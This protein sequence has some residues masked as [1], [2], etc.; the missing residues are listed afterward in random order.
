M[1]EDMMTNIQMI[2]TVAM[3][4]G[5]LNNEVVFLGGA[6]TELLITDPAAPQTRVSLDVDVIIEIPSRRDFYKLEDDLRSRG[7]TQSDNEDD[8]PICRWRIQNIIVDVMP[9]DSRILGFSNMWYSPA[10]KT[11]TRYD[12]DNHIHIQLVTAPYFLATK[13]EAFYGRGKGDYLGSH[14]MEDIVALLDGRQEIVYEIGETSEELRTYLSKEFQDF[15]HNEA[16]LESLSGHLPSDRTS[17]ARYPLLLERM[18]HIAHT[19]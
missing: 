18:K 8:D 9:T 17:Q 1:I 16:F 15:L 10:I 6:T 7:F 19:E 5:S 3:R 11:A 13:I 12:I 2:K 4:L 14:D